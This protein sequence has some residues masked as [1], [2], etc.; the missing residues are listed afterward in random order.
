MLF[1]ERFVKLKYIWGKILYFF[2]ESHRTLTPIAKTYIIK[3]SYFVKFM[4]IFPLTI[5]T[6]HT[7]WLLT[8]YERLSKEENCPALV[9]GLRAC[10]HILYWILFV[11]TLSCYWESFDKKLKKNSKIIWLLFSSE[12]PS[13]SSTS[14]YLWVNFDC[15]FLILPKFPWTNTKLCVAMFFRLFTSS[16]TACPCLC[17]MHW[18]ISLK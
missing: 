14:S 10:F 7:E 6:C 11:W 4:A 16:C 3:K 1:S 5:N 13:I 8:K 12:K 9:G 18:F 2:Q 15:I 17:T